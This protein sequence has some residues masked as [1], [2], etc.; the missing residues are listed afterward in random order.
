MAA[1]FIIVEKQPQEA[2]D[3]TREEKQDMPNLLSLDEDTAVPPKKQ[4]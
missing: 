2:E 4:E 1:D 3:I